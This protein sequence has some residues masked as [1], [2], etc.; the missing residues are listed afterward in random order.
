VK[1]QR[2]DQIPDA[3]R[4]AIA[5]L[6]DERRRALWLLARCPNGCTEATCWHTVERQLDH[7]RELEAR[8]I[9]AVSPRLPAQGLQA[10]NRQRNLLP[11]RNWRLLS[12][13][14]KDRLRC[15]Q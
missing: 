15:D 2:P 11:A 9:G 5:K 12:F 4:G 1:R 6:S 3:R 7:Y 14:G 8:A 13:R 10:C